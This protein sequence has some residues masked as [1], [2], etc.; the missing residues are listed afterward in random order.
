MNNFL[1]TRKIAANELLSPVYYVYATYADMCT[2]STGRMPCMS[3]AKI[4]RFNVLCPGSLED[5]S[6]LVELGFVAP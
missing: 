3:L 4:G 5:G 2:N 6:Q 1:I